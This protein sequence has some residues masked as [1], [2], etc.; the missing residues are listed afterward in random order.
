MDI[1]APKVVSHPSSG[2]LPLGKRR[3]SSG[4]NGKMER[5]GW[6]Q[7]GLCVSVFAVYWH[8]ICCTLGDVRE[9][10]ELV[11]QGICTASGDRMVKWCVTKSQVNSVDVAWKRM[12]RRKQFRG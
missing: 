7:F 8:H 1:V 5:G 2:L 4:D 3:N 10:R 12:S 6:V 11:K 9:P